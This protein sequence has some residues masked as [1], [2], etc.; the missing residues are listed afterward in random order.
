MGTPCASAVMTPNNG[1]LFCKGLLH[2]PQH[3]WGA[4]MPKDAATHIRNVF[5]HECSGIPSNQA[6]VYCVAPAMDPRAS[7][8]RVC[9]RRLQTE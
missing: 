3:L 1:A 4:A 6:I 5:I 9:S 2:G 7:E 8:L